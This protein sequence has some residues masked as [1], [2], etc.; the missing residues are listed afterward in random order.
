MILEK[1]TY[2]L[3]SLKKSNQKNLRG[4]RGSSKV[5][6]IATA[7]PIVA[8]LKSPRTSLVTSF[9]FLCLKFIAIPI[10]HPAITPRNTALVLL[11]IFA[12]QGILHPIFENQTGI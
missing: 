1:D 7:A 12:G 8:L 4:I 5:I 11:G 6:K 3:G 10:S 2:Q 9:L